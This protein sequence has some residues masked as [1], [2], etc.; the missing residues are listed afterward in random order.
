MLSAQS[1]I[2]KREGEKIDEIENLVCQAL[3]EMEMN[4]DIKNQLR[5][6]QIVGVKEYAVKGKKALAIF[7]P[8]P[9][10]K[11]WQK[12][13]TRLVREL[14]KK[15]SGKH[16]VFVAK[17][18]ILAKPN[19]KSRVNK[20]KRPINRTLTSVHD[21]YLADLVY[22]A[23]IVGKRTR[24]R[25]DGSTLIKVHLDKSSQT[26]IEHKIDTFTGVYKNLTGK[27]VVF[28]FPDPIF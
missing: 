24:I 18:T 19:R 17:R 23:E 4:S 28:Q 6:L 25:L 16:V 10:L 15:F 8:P 1:K 20:Q 21:A 11:G 27:N 26:S 7:I 14:E 22:P 9:Q 3:F 12:L 5:E 13:Q 2:K